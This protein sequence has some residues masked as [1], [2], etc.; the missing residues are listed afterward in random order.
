MKLACLLLGHDW[1]EFFKLRQHGQKWEPEKVAGVKI[2]KRCGKVEEVQEGINTITTYT[3]TYYGTER[4][5]H[6]NCSIIVLT[7]KSDASHHI[8][9]VFCIGFILAALGEFG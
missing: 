3:I 6:N 8:V 7:V 5:H 2:C 9:R 4:K 1:E